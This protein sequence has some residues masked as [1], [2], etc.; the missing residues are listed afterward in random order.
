MMAA[1][2]RMKFGLT[3][4]EFVL[5]QN[6]TAPPLSKNAFRCVCCVLRLERSIAGDG[7]CNGAAA[8]FD[9]TFQ[10]EDLLPGA[11]HRFAVGHRNG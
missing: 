1:N 7:H 11:E 10:M 4:L 6:V 8:W 3:R 5:L 9:I 2:G